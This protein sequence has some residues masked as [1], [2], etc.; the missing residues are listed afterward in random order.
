MYLKDRGLGDR[1]YRLYH[2]SGPRCYLYRDTLTCFVLVCVVYIT[3]EC[4]AASV[5][6]KG[7]LYIS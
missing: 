4:T 5:V 2:P 7:F 3:N 1:E 6:D